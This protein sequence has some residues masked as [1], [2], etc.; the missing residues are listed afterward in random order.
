MKSLLYILLLLIAPQ[1]FGGPFD[2]PPTDQ[3]VTLL[4]VIFGDSVG[5]IYLG[6][7]PNSVLSSMMEK[8]NFI[9]V[10]VGIVVVAYV[11]ILSTIN[12]AH[13]GTAMGKRWSAIWIPMRSVAGMALMV[14]A[15]ASGYSM[16]QV[17]VLW[18]VIQGIG[19]ADSLWNIALDGLASGVSA[20]AGSFPDPSLSSDNASVKSLVNSVLNAAVCMQTLYASAATPENVQGET[21]LNQHGQAI[22]NF[23][24]QDPSTPTISGTAPNR[25]ATVRGYSYFGVNDPSN[26]GD[27][28]I[29]GKLEVV[30]KVTESIDL[31]RSSEENGA[32]P[33]SDSDLMSYAQTIYDS[34]NTAIS[35]MLYVLSPL[36]DGLVSGQYATADYSAITGLN[37]SNYNLP[38]GG[39]ATAAAN[40]YVLRMKSLTIPLGAIYGPA[41]GPVT[42]NPVDS[43]EDLGQNIEGIGSAVLD[44]TSIENTLANTQ[45][46]ISQGK[47]NG[48]ITAGSF[49]FIFNQTLTSSI[50]QSAMPSGPDAIVEG[51][52]PDG[53]PRCDTVGGAVSCANMVLNNSGTATFTDI[54][55]KQLINNNDLQRL[56]FNL[57]NASTFIEN[58]TT[59]ASTQL[60]FPT[61]GVDSGPVAALIG[62]FNSSGAAIVTFMGNLMEK[63]GEG[64]AG[65][66]LLAHALFGRYIMLI[67]EGSLIAILVIIIVAFGSGFVPFIGGILVIMAVLLLGLLSILFPL[68]AVMW[69]MG[70]LLA[71][72]CPLIPYMIFTMGAV[73][74]ML[75]VVEAIVA[76]PIV[77]LGLI[78]PSDDD[79]GKLAAALPILANIFLRPMLM[80]FGFILA[81][82][83]FKAVVQ[84][85]DFGMA[86]VFQTIAVG[87][88][89]SGIVVV[90]V[91]VMFILSITNICFSLIYALPDKILR[92]I[93]GHPEG[94]DV[95][96]L[97]EVKSAAQG[98]GNQVGQGIGEV[99]GKAAKGVAKAGEAV[100]KAGISAITKK[101]PP[102]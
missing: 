31:R 36:V 53:I 99:G 5:S 14:P 83:L 13:E 61:P 9:I 81:S 25:I 42:L 72:Y 47:D 65:D 48:W 40:A 17:T 23:S 38:P 90:V 35:S 44:Q 67:V 54:Q 101:P 87:T 28:A 45:A 52:A 63:V 15:P 8:F 41:A 46:I 100:G 78:M 43:V 22:K 12:T 84:L 29:C 86:A 88:L 93:G 79:M 96:N 77:A 32:Q 7:A 10:V 64:S 69:G 76:A 26:P 59:V 33:L 75:V 102:P 18:I 97:A 51:G 98:A 89:F 39:Y 1:V 16:I 34:K 49:Y 20:T 55:N 27:M 19:A 57:A 62:Q 21:W 73:G 66:P 2:P 6:G 91:Y 30:G 58:D 82:N 68:F 11:A 70:A 74:W 80:I 3:S 94:T 60:N 71:I 50:F 92:W 37:P 24:I 4:G 85:I 56:G 95:S